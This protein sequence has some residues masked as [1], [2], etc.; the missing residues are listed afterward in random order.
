VEILGLV[1]AGTATARRAE[2]VAFARDVLA[3][4]GPEL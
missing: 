3:L 1:F 4:P 2:M